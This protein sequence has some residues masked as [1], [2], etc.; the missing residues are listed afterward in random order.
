MYLAVCVSC[1]M[2]VLRY[3]Y[4]AV[5]VSCGM[6]ILLYVYLAAC[7]SCGMC[8]LR[9]VYLVPISHRQFVGSLLYGTVC[10]KVKFSLCGGLQTVTELQ[11][12]KALELA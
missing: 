4:L 5:C 3:V 6:C 12:K 10:F 7:V 9:H 2:C 8:I 1:G 11:Y